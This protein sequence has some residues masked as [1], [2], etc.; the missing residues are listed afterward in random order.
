MTRQHANLKPLEGRDSERGN[1]VLISALLV[2]F[3]SLSGV[4]LSRLVQM[5]LQ[6]SADIRYANVAPTLAQLNAESGING[7][8]FAWNTGGTAPG[9]IPVATVSLNSVT[10]DFPYTG[11]P[12]VRTVTTNCSYVISAVTG[13]GPYVISATGYAVAQDPTVVPRLAVMSRTV[14][15]TASFVTN[16]W[17][18]TEYAR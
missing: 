2:L 6:Q 12:N 9:V 15:A 10:T 3:F 16:Q 4:G 14:Q 17:V 1:I 7:L 11:A 5:S 13:T 18:V 8:L